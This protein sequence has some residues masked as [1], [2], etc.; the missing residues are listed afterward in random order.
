[1]GKKKDP[2]PTLSDR[3][4]DT[5]PLINECYPGTD[6][7]CVINRQGDVLASANIGYLDPLVED[8][9]SAVAALRRAAVQFSKML[10][11][12]LCPVV[13]I[14]GDV[15]LFSCYDL[16][17]HVSSLAVR[18]HISSFIHAPADFSLPRL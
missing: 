4:Q 7:V 3:L 13:H 8:V 18:I 10:G 6:F 17:Q 11:Q 9:G 15:Q 1:V 2:E 14:A 12:G 16:G 5:L